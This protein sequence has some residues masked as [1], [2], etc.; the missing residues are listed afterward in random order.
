MQEALLDDLSNNKITIDDYAIRDE[1]YEGFIEIQRAKL[2]HTEGV[3]IMELLAAA[4]PFGSRG[5]E[6]LVGNVV[7]T[8]SSKG[9]T[10]KMI[11]DRA[12]ARLSSG[13]FWG[14]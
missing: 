4:K 2:E 9:D 13:H 5:I 6:E 7:K 10:Y 1:Q 3:E 8:P 11:I 14:R 12:E